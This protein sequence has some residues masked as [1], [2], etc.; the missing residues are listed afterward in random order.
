MLEQRPRV[1]E[2]EL[3]RRRSV[4]SVTSTRRTST[5]PA[6]GG[7]KRVSTSSDSTRP[8]DPTC[9]AIHAATVPAPEPTS[10][11]CQPGAM[12]TSVKCAAGAAVGDAREHAQA[13]VLAPHL[14]GVVVDAV[15]LRSSSATA[16]RQLAVRDVA[17]DARFGRETEHTFADHRAVHLVRPAADRRPRTARAA[18]AASRRRARRPRRA[19]PRRARPARAAPPTTAPSSPSRRSR[20]G[21]PRASTPAPAASCTRGSV[22]C[23]YAAREALAHERIARAVEVARQRDERGVA[24]RGG[25]AAADH[26]RLVRE[27]RARRPP[28]RRRSHR[29]R[30]RPGCARRSGTPR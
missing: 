28:N 23:V 20:A 26:R 6:L 9:S 7:W 19:A 2:V 27:H 1:H 18:G 12:P 13:V 8:V 24:Q 3:V 4:R 11:Q 21:S 14:I 5:T 22:R 15:R 10:Q 16:C 25:V 30:S 17:V 29:R